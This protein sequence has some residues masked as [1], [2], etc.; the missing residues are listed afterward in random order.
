MI[1]SLLR[2]TW[3]ILNSIDQIKTDT[4]Q[5]WYLEFLILSTIHIDIIET[6]HFWSPKWLTLAGID[7]WNNWHKLFLILGIIHLQHVWYKTW[8]IHDM[9]DFGISHF[10]N[11]WYWT[12]SK[13]RDGCHHLLLIYDSLMISSAVYFIKLQVLGL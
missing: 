1:L 8:L 9:T 11:F 4:C 10:W 5:H 2:L 6:W 13:I 3:L 12:L 7:A